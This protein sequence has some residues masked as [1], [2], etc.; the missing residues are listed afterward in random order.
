[1]GLPAVVTDIRGC[2][3]AVD[4][5]VTGYV[6]PLRDPQALADALVDLLTDDRK[7]AEFGQA[8]RRKALAE[9]DERALFERILAVYR[10]LLA[11]RGVPA[12]NPQLRL[13]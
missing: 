5:G 8:A 1:M 9:F 10:E 7:R 11:R 6:V 2:R 4:H 12:P 3:Q 13:A